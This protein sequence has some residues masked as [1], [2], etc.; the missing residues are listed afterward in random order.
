MAPLNRLTHYKTIVGGDL[1]FVTAWGPA[2]RPLA[3][4]MFKDGGQP[5][6]QPDRVAAVVH[7]RT[8][9]PSV[10]PTWPE[11]SSL[12]APMNEGVVDVRPAQHRAGRL[13]QRRVIRCDRGAVGQLHSDIA[14]RWAPGRAR[15]SCR[16]RGRR[17]PRRR[18][19]ARTR[20]R[21]RVSTVPA[22]PV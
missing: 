17:R 18:R 11:Q 10:A 9:V 4:L 12:S 20:S 8:V 2:R 5:R 6:P 19:I 16:P 7:L 14:R 15:R 13:G 1:D 22:C 21:F 3:M